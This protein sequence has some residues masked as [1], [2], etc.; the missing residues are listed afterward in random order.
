MSWLD[1]LLNKIDYSSHFPKGKQSGQRNQILVNCP[2]HDD[3]HASLS[4]NLDKGI[5]YCHTCNE[6]GNFVNWADKQKIDLK[7][8]ASQY[9]IES[10]EKTISKD[11]VDEAHEALIK[12]PSYIEWME[13]KRGINLD[14]I[15]RFKIGVHNK[16][17]TIPITSITRE[18]VNIRMYNP[19]GKGSAKVVSWKAGFGSARLYP[20]MNLNKNPIMLCEGEMD[21]LL[22]NQL[23]YFAVTG[24]TGAGTFP[25]EWAKYFGGKDVLICYDIDD[26]GKSG[27]AKVARMLSKYASTIKI[28]N[29]PINKSEI[30]T[31]DLTDYIVQL[32]HS[33]KHLDQ[34]IEKTEPYKTEQ[35]GERE[36]HD[37]PLDIAT[38]SKYNNEYI[39][40][41]AL[42]SGK[43]I[44]AFLVPKTIKYS[45]TVSAGKICSSCPMSFENGSLQYIIEPTDENILLICNSGKKE[46]ENTLKDLTGIPPRCGVVQ[47]EEIDSYNV[48]EIILTT[49]IE[50]TTNVE[51]DEKFTIRTAHFIGHNIETN[52]T[53]NFEGKTVAH[54]KTQYATHLMYKADPSLSSIENFEMTDSIQK[55]INKFKSD[56]VASKLKDIYEST[57]THVSGLRG[58]QDL[59]TAIFLTYC[60]PLAF[61]FDGRLV[62]K[63][64]LETLV[65][66]DTRCGKTEMMKSLIEYFR[67]GELVLGESA[68]FAGLVGGLQQ[69]GNRWHLH[70]GRIPLNNRRLVA[71]DEM[72]GLPTWEI[73]KLSGIR[74]S[75][76][77]EI[78]KIRTE[79]TWSR[80]RLIWLSNPRGTKDDDKKMLAAYSQGVR[81]VSE[82]VGKSEDISRFD[83]VLLLGI[84]DVPLSLINEI[85]VKPKSFTYKGED[86][87]SLIRWAWHLKSDDI[88][89]TD[90]SRDLIYTCANE[91]ATK[92]DQSIPLVVPSE[93]R[94]KLARMAVACAIMTGHVV[95]EKIV[96]EPNHVEFVH[97]YL[98]EI[99]DKH[100]CSYDEYSRLEKARYTLR[101]TEKVKEYLNKDTNIVDQLLDVERITQTDLQEIFNLDV[102][103]EIRKLVNQF[104]S[105]K[106]LK[107]CSAGYEKTPAFI[108]FLRHYKTN[109]VHDEDQDRTTEVTHQ[110]EVDEAFDE[111]DKRFDED[112]APF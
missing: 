61:E 51:Q 95:D 65:L 12:V 21:C 31:G 87:H 73:A 39:K 89:I 111:I 35:L 46:K 102:R 67:I 13:R 22:A 76:I 77:A 62:K 28:I 88:V 2:F 69:V 18:I 10:E 11:D 94:I 50:Y 53:Y 55:S 105:S 100:I 4:I 34:I 3:K 24:T 80:T 6:K 58:R 66:G 83:I 30:P 68:S 99:Y 57:I 9:G 90:E 72:S 54:P 97:N 79:R 14:T 19:T 108:Q 42:V 47:F 29:L 96:V 23:G 71:I 27:A 112:K 1:D 16:C 81:A 32:G 25:S 86:F 104:V 37:V 17:F 45:C 78:T 20:A 56:D 107:R 41:K 70:W 75:G 15:K 98:N 101:N 64:W 93:Q 43:D 33:K 38:N 84:E 60:S 26:A 40:T 49:E 52:R 103:S 7:Q 109:G 48:E 63:G 91:M 106:A 59:F 110:V 8:L 92:Y 44:E 5:Y 36:F 85:V 82:L 74:S